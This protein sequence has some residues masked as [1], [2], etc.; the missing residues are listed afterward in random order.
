M[1]NIRL[2]NWTVATL[3]IVYTDYYKTLNSEV[4]QFRHCNVSLIWKVYY[5]QV[6]Q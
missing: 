1:A 6:R 5:K 2:S 3:S 4:M